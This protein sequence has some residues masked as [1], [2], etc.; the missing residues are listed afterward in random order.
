LGFFFEWRIV[1]DPELVTLVPEE[2][3]EEL[4]PSSHELGRRLAVQ[5]VAVIFLK[6]ATG[7]AIKNLTRTIRQIDVLYPE[8]L[9]RINW[10]ANR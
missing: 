7:I 4:P 9:D 6:V 8:T 2:E 1:E 3:P 5:V 10:K